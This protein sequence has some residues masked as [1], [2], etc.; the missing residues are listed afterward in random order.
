[1]KADEKNGIL[2]YVW[3]G[4]MY[5]IAVALKPQALMIGP[6]YALVFIVKGINEIKNKQ[7]VKNTV[8]GAALAA[9]C[10]FAMIIIPALPFKGSQE[11]L[12]LID[13]YAGTAS[14]YNFA[15]VE[16]YNFFTLLGANW[17]NADTVFMLGLTYKQV[18][19]IFMAIS[20]IAAV[21]LYIVFCKKNRKNAV[22]AVIA[23][24]LAGIFTF[25][26]YMH[27]RYLFPAVI[28]VLFA[29]VF[30]ND[31]RLFISYLTM[32]CSMLYNSMGAFLITDCRQLDEYKMVQIT[33]YP[34]FIAIGSC[35]TIAA[36]AYFAYTVISMAF[37][38][39]PQKHSAYS[40]DITDNNGIKDDT[41]ETDMLEI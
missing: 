37:E 19:T 5:G 21:I 28:F 34:T 33:S 23:F 12:W 3:S 13:K 31:R 14:S 29:F 27:E 15:S 25:G 30:L 7:P 1:M 41:T 4:I 11:G 8:I 10:A 38:T 18:G 22:Y 35:L 26:H 40:I 20:I 17:K 32:T 9:V 39:N 16:A 24:M 2:D 36:F 6:M